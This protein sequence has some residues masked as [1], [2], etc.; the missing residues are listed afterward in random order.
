MQNPW[1]HFTVSL[2]V[3]SIHMLVILVRKEKRR[4]RLKLGRLLQFF[5][6]DFFFLYFS[7]LSILFL[8]ECLN[9]NN[10]M[11]REKHYLVDELN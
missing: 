10:K 8:F 11:A 5:E 7:I 9:V 1:S 4:I 2:R 3:R 6:L